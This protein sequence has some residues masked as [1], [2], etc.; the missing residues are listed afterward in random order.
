MFWY[1]LY[2][3]DLPAAAVFR[4]TS[5]LRRDILSREVVTHTDQSVKMLHATHNRNHSTFNELSLYLL[6]N[7]LLFSGAKTNVSFQKVFYFYFF[8]SVN[9]T[10]HAKLALWV[11]GAGGGGGE[12]GGGARVG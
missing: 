8:N 10:S 2:L 6:W 12:R 11:G 5:S 7:R 1:T 3:V 9:V 4:S